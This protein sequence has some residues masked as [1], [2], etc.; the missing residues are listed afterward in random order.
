MLMLFQSLIARCELSLRKDGKGVW[1]MSARG[2][3]AVVGV[4]VLL[5]LHHFAS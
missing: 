4:L 2:P 3:L 1:Q 5:M